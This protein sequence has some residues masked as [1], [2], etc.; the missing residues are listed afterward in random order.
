MDWFKA[1]GEAE[2]IFRLMHLLD[3]QHTYA[4]FRIPADYSMATSRQAR[5]Q[6]RAG[7]APAATNGA[8]GNLSETAVWGL[9]CMYH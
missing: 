7:A 3:E 5:G 8:T 2:E 6:S 9:L 1:V 4:L